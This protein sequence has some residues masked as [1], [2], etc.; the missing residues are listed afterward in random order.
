MK[1]AYFDCFS[2]AG[3]DMIVAAMLDAGLNAE[4]LK[5][6]IATL[7]IKGLDI[8]ITETRRGG[9][10][11]LSFVP[12]ISEQHH[13]RNL[14][15]IKEIISQSEISEQAKKTAVKIFKSLHRPR[16]PSTAKMPMKFT[17]TR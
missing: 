7:N 1:I 17:S 3:G 11:A 5:S 13:H 8:K 12:Q 16:Q 15:Q 4:F 6:Q 10:R 9:L 14:Q 2:G